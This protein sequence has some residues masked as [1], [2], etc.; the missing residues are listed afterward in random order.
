MAKCNCVILKYE[1]YT[2]FI[3]HTEEQFEFELQL[4]ITFNEN[5]SFVQYT[6]LSQ[7][8]SYN[9]YSNFYKYVFQY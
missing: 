2:K 7:E 6:V 5:F 3:E 4:N 9:C 1:T 8:N